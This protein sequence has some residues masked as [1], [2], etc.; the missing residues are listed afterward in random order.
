MH[1][2]ASIRSQGPSPARIAARAVGTILPMLGLVLGM[3]PALARAEA[4]PRVSAATTMDQAGMVDIRRLVP[5][6]SQEIAYRG[7]DNFVGTPVEGYE[8]PRC[9]LKRDAAE[10]LARVD[11]DLR[12]NN[13]RLRIYDCYRP[14][15]AV[16]HFVRW[17]HDLDDQRTKATHYPA[18]DK[19]ELLDGYIAPVSGHSR[20]RTVDLTVLR[21]DDRGGACEPLDMGTHFDYFGTRANTDTAEVSAAQLANRHLLRDAMQAHGFSNY[22]MEWWHYTLAVDGPPGELY[23]VP[24]T[25]PAE[26]AWQAELDRLMAPYDGD[27]PGAALLVLKDGKPLVRRGYG[28]ADLERETEAGPATSYRLASVSKAFTAGAVLLLAQDGKL[29]LDDPVRKWLPSLP[30]VADGITLHHLLAHTSGLIEYDELEPRPYQGQMRDIDVLR[31]L[32]QENR[33]Y[34]EPGSQYRYSNAGYALL[35]LVI[36]RASGM[37]FPDYLRTRIFEPLG[38]HDSLAYVVGGPEAPRRAWGYSRTPD[39]WTRTD[40]NHF[41][42]ILGDGG[43]YSSLGDMARWD[44]AWNDDRLFSDAT[45][46]LAFARQVQVSADPEP[47]YYGYG[48]RVADGR[49]W[50]NG[51]SIGFRNSYVRWPEQGLSVILLSNRNDPTPYPTAVQIGELILRERGVADP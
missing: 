17:A 41:S 36:E 22:P 9:W 46:A 47:T 49:Q 19:T 40:Q 43:V 24:V 5:D 39:G 26:P 7:S 16:A 4:P 27:V 25:A 28:R 37:A 3:A 31:L 35:A 45:R 48:W 2:I 51:E 20:G 38:M 34:F 42:Q 44:A 50:H 23:D 21:C 33:L 14:T 12:E 15:R 10:A 11:A 8:A 6:M 1:A 29:S 18:L 13:L 30:Q 32:E